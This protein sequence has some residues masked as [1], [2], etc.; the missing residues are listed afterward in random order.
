MPPEIYY[1]NTDVAGD[2]LQ[3]AISSTEVDAKA[4]VLCGGHFM[5]EMSNILNPSKTVLIP[6]LGA[7]CALAE[8]ITA[9]GIA[10]M[11]A[12]YPGEPVVTFV[13]TAVEAKA[14]ADMRNNFPEPSGDGEIRSRRTLPEAMAIR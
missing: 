12:K 14:A 13:N 1:D 8:S 9:A 2:G 10:E 4:N 6:D 3:L 5:A 11:R 7:G